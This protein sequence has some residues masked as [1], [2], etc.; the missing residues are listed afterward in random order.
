M[1]GMGAALLRLSH[2][3]ARGAPPALTSC[4]GRAGGQALPPAPASRNLTRSPPGK[5]ACVSPQLTRA[6]SFLCLSESLGSSGQVPTCQLFL[7]LVCSKL[8]L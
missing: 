5:R 4:H 3:K 6:C 7:S 8:L 2:R 1:G